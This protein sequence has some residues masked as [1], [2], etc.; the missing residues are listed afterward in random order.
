[1]GIFRKKQTPAMTEVW[2]VDLLNKFNSD[3]TELDVIES[4]IFISE[5]VLSM[6]S[7][8]HQPKFTNIREFDLSIREI[9]GSLDEEMFR[10]LIGMLR[11]EPEYLNRFISTAVSELEDTFLVLSD[12]LGHDI[13]MSSESVKRFSIVTTKTTLLIG[14]LSH[15]VSDL[16]ELL[17]TDSVVAIA[18]ISGKSRDFIARFLEEI[19]RTSKYLEDYRN[20]LIK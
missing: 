7:N 14:E 12:G 4:I 8:N 11:F 9:L 20:S 1:M 10:K 2:I 17:T 3:R 16:N 6:Q 5:G 18:N 19:S 15:I 13:P